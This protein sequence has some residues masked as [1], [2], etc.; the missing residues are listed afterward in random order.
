MTSRIGTAARFGLIPSDRWVSSLVWQNLGVSMALGIII[1]MAAAALAH[2]TTLA[3]GYE[4]AGIVALTAIAVLSA[5][6]SGL[7]MSLVS[8]LTMRVAFRRGLDMDNIAGP[9]I[10][11]TGDVFT[12][13]ALWVSTHALG[14]AA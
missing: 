6:L 12:L 1:S 2:V 9:I 3:L 7:A 5:V 14:V 10:M 11:T 4:S 13:A 8:V